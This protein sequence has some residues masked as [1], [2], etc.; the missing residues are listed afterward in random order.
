MSIIDDHLKRISEMI[1]IQKE[2]SKLGFEFNE[3]DI[4]V[5]NYILGSNNISVIFK[6]NETIVEDIRDF[7]S[8][9]LNS[10]KEI[11]D[12]VKD[13]VVEDSYKM[14]NNNFFLAK[15]ELGFNSAIEYYAN[16]NKWIYNEILRPND[17]QY[18]VI[19]HL[20]L[21]PDMHIDHDSEYKL[22]CDIVSVKDIREII[23]E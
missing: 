20:H 22:K 17:I 21:T 19:V 4:E 7:A 8:F 18:P 16:K 23:T 11:L 5:M 2:L 3:D 12:I 10:K 6:R 15:N 13:L 14:I 1:E 9:D